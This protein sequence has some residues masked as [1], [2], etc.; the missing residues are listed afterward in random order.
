MSRI[1][2]DLK[3]DNTAIELSMLDE[4]LLPYVNGIPSELGPE[5]REAFYQ[6]LSHG[7]VAKAAVFA[8]QD[9]GVTLR[10][11]ARH[12]ADFAFIRSM[13]WII[14]CLLIYIAYRVS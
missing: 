8:R 9:A 3:A 11:V 4:G 5:D 12:S 1:S 10:T 13:L 7:H 14:L 2:E 6:N